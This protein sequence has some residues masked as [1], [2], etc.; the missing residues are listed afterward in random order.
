LIATSSLAA[1]LSISFAL[2][3][4]GRPGRVQLLGTPAEESG[5]GKVELLNAGAFNGVDVSLMA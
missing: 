1:F 5:G 4:F 2:K 3:D